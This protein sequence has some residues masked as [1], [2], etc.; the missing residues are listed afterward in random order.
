MVFGGFVGRRARPRR[1][2]WF[3]FRWLLL[4]LS[5]V[6]GAAVWGV[7]ARGIGIYLAQE[8]RDTGFFLRHFRIE[9]DINFKMEQ[10]M[11]LASCDERYA[12]RPRRI[13]I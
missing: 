1:A 8:K 10:R 7:I 11:R 5:R 3:C 13:S 12:T 4:A 6:W 2:W 9:I